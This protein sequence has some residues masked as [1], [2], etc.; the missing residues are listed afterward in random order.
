MG[1][2]TGFPRVLLQLEG[3]VMFGLSTFFYFA[4]DMSWKL[5]LLFILAPDLAM[6]AYLLGKRIGTLAYNLAHTYSVPCLKTAFG[7][8]FSNDLMT[9]IGLIWISHIGFDRMVGYGLKY[10]HSFKATHLS[11]SE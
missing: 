2:V 1:S 7:F 5:Y 4:Q 3:L 9:A 11:H 6:I 8:V 10:S